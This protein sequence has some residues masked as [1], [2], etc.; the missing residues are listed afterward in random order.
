LDRTLPIR[1]EEK[2]YGH[3]KGYQVRAPGLFLPDDFGQVL[4]RRMRGNGEDAGHRLYVRA[5]RLQG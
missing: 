2:K 1:S 4:Q 5:S 3:G